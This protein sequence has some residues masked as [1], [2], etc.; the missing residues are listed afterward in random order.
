LAGSLPPCLRAMVSDSEW[1][2]FG[3]PSLHTS[4]NGTLVLRG[5]WKRGDIEACIG[6]TMKPHVTPD[7]GRLYRI[8]D[9][10]WLDFID[11]HTAF[12]TKHAELPAER[13][14]DLVKHGAGPPAHARELVAKL[15]ADRSIAFVIDGTDGED[16]IES[17]LSL[18]KTSDLYGWVRIEPDFAALDLAADAHAAAPAKAAADATRAQIE[19]VFGKASEGM[20]GKLEVVQDKTVVHVRGK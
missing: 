14:H 1:V 6:D 5:R 3:A 20:I 16:V 11:E 17:S 7:G 4:E 2:A 12:I 8:G 10:F 19:G 15:P 18:P 13:V 9:D